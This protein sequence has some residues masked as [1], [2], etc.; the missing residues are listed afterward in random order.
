MTEEKDLVAEYIFGTIRQVAWR[1]GVIM[2]SV[3][4]IMGILAAIIVPWCLRWAGEML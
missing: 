3:G 2:Y 1:T 4:F